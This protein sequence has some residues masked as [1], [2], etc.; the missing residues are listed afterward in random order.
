LKEIRAQRKAEAVARKVA[1]REKRD[2]E[3]R[4]KDLENEIL[5]FEEKQKRLTTELEDPDTYADPAR[6]LELNRELEGVVE[7]LNR[8]NAEWE[9]AVED[10]QALT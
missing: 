2:R 3:K 5:R 8:V 7:T 4:V 9:A 1:N 6:A 10:V